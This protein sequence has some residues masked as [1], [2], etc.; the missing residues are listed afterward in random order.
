M[1][2]NLDL[3]HDFTIS[4]KSKERYLWRDIRCHLDQLYLGT[5]DREIEPSGDN[6]RTA[7]T[8]I[9]RRIAYGDLVISPARNLNLFANELGGHSLKISEVRHCAGRL[10]RAKLSL[11]FISKREHAIQCLT[12]TVSILHCDTFVPQYNR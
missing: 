10:G 9:P 7:R 1:G 4:R 12:E 5:A 3:L 11:Q 8:P 6:I 2:R